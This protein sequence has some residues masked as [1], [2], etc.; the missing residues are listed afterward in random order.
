[1]SIKRSAFVFVIAGLAIAPSRAQEANDVREE[2]LDHGNVTIL[3]DQKGAAD[4]RFTLW[5]SYPTRSA[6][7]LDHAQYLADLQSRFGDK[8]IAV[9][10]ALPKADAA[11]VASNKPRMI[12][13]AANNED[14]LAGI[15]GMSGVVTESTSGATVATMKSL[16]LAVDIM[17]SLLTDTHDGQDQNAA[18]NVL[19]A[20][21]ANI[22]DGGPFDTAVNQCLTSFPHSGRAHACAVLNQWWC[23]GDLAAARKAIDAGLQALSNDAVPMAIFVDLVLR[24]DRN[25]PQLARRLTMAMT[26]VAAGA[27]DGAFTQLVYLRA[28]LRDGQ[29]RTAGRICATLPKRIVGRADLQLIFAETLMESRNPVAHRDGAERAIQTAEANGGAR[30]WVYAARHK[31]LKRCQENQAAEQ[32]MDE[33]RAKNL[34]AGFNNDAWYLIVQPQTMGRFDSMALAQ[35]EEMLRVDKNTDYGS[36]D[37]VALAHFVNGKLK[38]AIEMETPAAQ[39]SGDNPIYVAR[40]TRYKATLAERDARASKEKQQK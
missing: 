37:T 29:E 25:D 32:L 17:Q 34:G 26:P 38:K 24:G 10:V 7:F 12:V 39:Q 16:D 21:L 19:K 9:A 22:A 5:I 28:L 1:M 3:H 36:M 14:Q 33:Y 4:A 40:L 35:C 13:A 11:A 15:L 30:K 20:T 8:G 18:R 31:L 2:R 27:S 23:K 6:D